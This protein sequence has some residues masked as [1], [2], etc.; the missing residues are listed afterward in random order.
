MSFFDTAAIAKTE[1]RTG[2]IEQGVYTVEIEALEIKD[3]K[4]NDGQFIEVVLVLEGSNR[5]LFPYAV[6]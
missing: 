4:A 3:T 6:P 1:V 2:I 5:K